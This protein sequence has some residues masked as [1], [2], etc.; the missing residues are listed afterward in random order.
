MLHNLSRRCRFRSD[1]YTA[2]AMKAVSSYKRTNMRAVYMNKE[3]NMRCLTF[4]NQQSSEQRNTD[5]IYIYQLA[6][7]EHQKNHAL[8]RAAWCM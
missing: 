8:K 3:I 4:G 6:K 7:K 2:L 5:K 1:R